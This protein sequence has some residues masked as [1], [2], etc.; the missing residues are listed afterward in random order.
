[1]TIG[2][3][4]DNNISIVVYTCLVVVALAKPRF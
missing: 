4:T 1:M 2:E 3:T